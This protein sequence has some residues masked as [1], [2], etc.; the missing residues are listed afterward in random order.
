MKG[1]SLV[2]RDKRDRVNPKDFIVDNVSSQT[3]CRLPDSVKGQQFIIQNCQ[4]CSIFVF[5]QMASVTVDDCSNCLIFLGPIKSSV[6]IR[7]CTNCR[8]MV[9]CQQFRTRDCKQMEI[10]LCCATQPIIESSTGMKF[11]C[12]Q[13]HYLHLEEQ[14]RSAGLS[15]YNNNWSDIHDFTPVPD[16]KNFSFLPQDTPMEGYLPTTEG[17]PVEQ[18]TTE[19]SSSVVP[20]TLGKRRKPYDESCL[21]V[22]FS[23][24]QHC[25]KGTKAFIRRMANEHAECLLVQSK[26]VRLKVDESE[27]IFGSS[28]YS[29]IVVQGPVVGLEYNGPNCCNICRELARGQSE[30]DVFISNNA[31]EA[32]NQ[33]ESFYNVAQMHLA[34]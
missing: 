28:R 26:E 33:V 4:D 14:F 11:T 21:V 24:D 8:I 20:C 7:D 34:I 32:T 9:A 10:F 17:V 15:V 22:F 1:V 2:D 3:I 13:Y 16:E 18:L 31:E 6:F 23:Q 5:D 12:F 27:R 29:T 30:G 19:R 25:N